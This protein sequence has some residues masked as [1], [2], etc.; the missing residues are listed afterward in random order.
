[1]LRVYDG[2]LWYAHSE[3]L[4]SNLNEYWHHINVIHD[5]DSRDTQVYVNGTLKLSKKD[6]GK[7]EHYFKLG[8]YQQDNPSQ[9]T[10]VYIKNIKTYTK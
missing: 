6:N 7:A 4:I 3:K 9:K 10:E 5:A 1:M 8:V 2:A